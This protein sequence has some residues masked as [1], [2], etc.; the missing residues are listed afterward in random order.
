MPRGI[1]QHYFGELSP[2]W[3]GGIP[4]CVKC[5]KKLTN[6]SKVRKNYRTGKHFISKNMCRKCYLLWWKSNAISGKNHKS[7]KGGILI[8]S[9]GYIL[10][11]TKG[12][13]Y[14]RGYRNRSRI[15]TEKYLN[16]LLKSSEI[17]HH[18]NEIRNDDRPEN[19]YLFKSRKEHY[20]FHLLKNK[21]ILKSNLNSIPRN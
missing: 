19:L 16:R 18:I 21:P 10:I 15:I 17:I 2:R 8:D 3:K 4:K 6:Y 5:G 14:N 11:K 7:W 1:Y 9:H 12:D 20:K 13:K